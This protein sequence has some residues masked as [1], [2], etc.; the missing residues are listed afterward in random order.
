M[1]LISVV[2]RLDHTKVPMQQPESLQA[3]VYLSGRYL[4]RF[5]W[6]QWV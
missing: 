1:S 2:D 6:H 3:V 4:K 5:L